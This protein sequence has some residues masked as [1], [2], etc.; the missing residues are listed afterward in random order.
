MKKHLELLEHINEVMKQWITDPEVNEL[1]TKLTDV[2]NEVRVSDKV[3]AELKEDDFIDVVLN[4]DLE[5]HIKRN[6]CGYSIDAYKHWPE[7]EMTEDH[8]Y[9]NDF[10]D[11]LVIDDDTLDNITNEEI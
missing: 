3:D 6:D 11:A 9:D 8:D 1:V 7:E 5:L 4:H 2:I 10:I